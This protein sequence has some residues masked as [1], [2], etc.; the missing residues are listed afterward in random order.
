MASDWEIVKGPKS[1]W[2]QTNQPAQKQQPKPGAASGDWTDMLPGA[3][4]TGGQILGGILGTGAGVGAGAAIPG[5]DLTGVPEVAGGIGGE[6][7]GQTAGGALGQGVGESI[8]QWIQNISGK[9]KG[10]DPGAIGSET[11]QGG[12]YGAIPGSQFLKGPASFAT[13]AL[14]TGAKNFAGGAVVGG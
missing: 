13:R 6:R 4:G 14:A 1:D 11:A 12:L 9:T 3:F 10:F 8:R 7:I 5:A 2:E